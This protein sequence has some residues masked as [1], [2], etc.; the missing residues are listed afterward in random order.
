MSKSRVYIKES[1]IQKIV[2]HLI[3]CKE[4]VFEFY[5]NKVEFGKETATMILKRKL[6]LI[7]AESY[8]DFMSKFITEELKTITAQYK[9]HT[10]ISHSK[11][12]KNDKYPIWICWLQG[13]EYMPEIC[14]ICVDRMRKKLPYNA[15]IIFLTYENYLNYIDIPKDIVK[16]HE[17]GKISPTNY[18]DIIRYGLLATYGGAWVDSAILFTGDILDRAITYEIF[19]PK[20]N[21]E[22]IED[23]SRG[24]W[25]GGCWFSQNGNILFDFAYDSLVFFWRKHDKAVEYLAAD[26]ILWTGYTELKE[27]KELIDSIPFN[28]EN[29]RL[30]NNCLYDTYDKQLYYEM[31]RDNQIHIINR[32]QNYPIYDKNGKETFYGHLISRNLE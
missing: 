29:I 20:F 7:S 27:A 21:N 14:R 25:V 31:L 3:I 12:K 30:L 6:N 24:K 18:T 19:T 1:L 22:K 17:E 11:E 13:E 4:A 28:N 16:K 8:I 23:A 2:R 15:E 5:S 9:N 32:H 26:Y 10:Y